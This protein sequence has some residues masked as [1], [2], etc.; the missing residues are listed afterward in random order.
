MQQSARK[1]VHWNWSNK[2][3]RVLLK[4]CHYR[5]FNKL[6]DML[7]FREKSR[8]KMNIDFK[9]KKDFVNI[10][11]KFNIAERHVSKIQ[12]QSLLDM[13]RI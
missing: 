7:A 3:S 4:N 5:F 12:D 1:F 6:Q 10:A 13:V 8:P 11:K 9:D 2:N